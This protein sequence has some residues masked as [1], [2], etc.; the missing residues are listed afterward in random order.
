MAFDYKGFFGEIALTHDLTS[1]P[2]A[3]TWPCRR[4]VRPLR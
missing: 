2:T 3:R 1:A 4:P